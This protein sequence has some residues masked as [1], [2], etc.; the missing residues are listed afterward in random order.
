LFQK[1]LIAIKGGGAAQLVECLPME[2]QI[3]GSNPHTDN[4]I[5]HNLSLMWIQNFDCHL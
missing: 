3:E 5:I 4:T 1:Q 2:L